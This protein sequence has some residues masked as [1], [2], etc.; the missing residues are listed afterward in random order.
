MAIEKE[1]I[2]D[3]VQSIILSGANNDEN[4]IRRGLQDLSDAG[5]NPIL[6]SKIIS[7]SGHRINFHINFLLQKIT[8]DK[9]DS[10]TNGEIISYYTKILN[11]FSMSSDVYWSNF[12]EERNMNDSE[13]QWMKAKWNQKQRCGKMPG[14]VV[15]I[16]S[17]KNLE[18]YVGDSKMEELISWLNENGIKE[19]AKEEVKKE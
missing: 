6:N 18:W 8:V 3:I 7:A 11:N 15:T 2:A 17:S 9:I 14:N 16:N 5:I 4:G 12:K 1:D 10:D 19:K 13:K